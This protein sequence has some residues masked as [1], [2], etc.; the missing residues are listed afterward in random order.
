[1]WFDIL[2]K[3][4]GRKVKM[5]LPTLKI[6]V[7]EWA[8]MNREGR[9]KPQDII[10]YVKDDVIAAS[11]NDWA[12]KHEKPNWA[13]SYIPTMIVQYTQK[14]ERKGLNFWMFYLGPTLKILGFKQRGA[15]N[16][17]R[18]EGYSGVI[19]QDEKDI[20]EMRERLKHEEDKRRKRKVG[21]HRYGGSAQRWEQERN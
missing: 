21:S 7:A 13:N 3:S 15:D 16:L 5:H 9:H 12:K 11:V 18:E 4:K 19:W 14:T 6:K 20:Q 1:M 17:E 8:E 10:D 2:K